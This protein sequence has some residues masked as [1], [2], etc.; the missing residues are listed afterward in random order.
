M[1]S[2]FSGKTTCPECHGTRLK[3]EANWVKINGMSITD[4][5]QMPIANLIEWFNHLELTEQEQAIGKR[6]LIEIKNRLSFFKRCGIRLFNA[7]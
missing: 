2:R 4:L 5:V 7:Q 3:K 6:L 1:I